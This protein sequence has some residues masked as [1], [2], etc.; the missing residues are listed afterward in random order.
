[1]HPTCDASYPNAGDHPN[2]VDLLNVTND[3]TV[4]G[5]KQ[6]GAVVEFRILELA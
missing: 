3:L 2:R 5:R 1:M 4:Y 6:A